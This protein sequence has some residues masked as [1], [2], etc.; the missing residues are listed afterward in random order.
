MSPG[1]AAPLLLEAG[2]FKRMLGVSTPGS[3]HAE[4]F[5]RRDLACS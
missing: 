2:E 3:V 1:L 4:L 5:P